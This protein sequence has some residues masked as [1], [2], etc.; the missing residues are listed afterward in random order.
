MVKALAYILV[1]YLLVCMTEILV[2]NKESKEIIF[3]EDLLKVYVRPLRSCR[4]MSQSKS[5]EKCMLDSTWNLLHAYLICALS[6]DRE[7]VDRSILIGKTKAFDRNNW[8]KRSVLRRFDCDQNVHSLCD[9][10]NH[11]RGW[12]QHQEE[13][14][15]FPALVLHLGPHSCPLLAFTVWPGWFWRLW[16]PFRKFRV[17]FHSRTRHQSLRD[18]CE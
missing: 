17:K 7:S 9:E 2:A 13:D 4:G 1:S 10:E 16:R 12:I 15:L 11:V 3:H 5:F 18:N 14:D 8:T 6:Q